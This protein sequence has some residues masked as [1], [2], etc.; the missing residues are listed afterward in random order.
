VRVL[1]SHRIELLDS[2][3]SHY[4]ILGLEQG[5]TQ[6]DI[7]KAYFELAKKLHPDKLQAAGLGDVKGDAQ[8]VFAAVNKAFGV[9]SDPKK[10]ADYQEVMAAG[11]EKAFARKKAAENKKAR[12][13]LEGEEHFYRGQK[14]LEQQR[15]A[16][17]KDAFKTA[18]ECNDQE[19]EF[20][21]CLAWSTWCAAEGDR[22]EIS[23]PV[24]EQMRK[25]LKLSPN[26][27]N[28]SFYQGLL[29]KQLDRLDEAL[30]AFNKTI[31]RDPRHHQAELELRLLTKRLASTDSDGGGGFFSRKKKS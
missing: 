25:A 6:A 24:L 27:P 3:G 18:V 12:R 11:G 19:G 26:N 29:Y 13:I 5:A 23:Q 31:E 21:V 20:L 30:M 10:A 15:F 4:D 14:A 1:I 22:D 16:Q 9:L 17:A 28:I 2:E 7:P 8:R